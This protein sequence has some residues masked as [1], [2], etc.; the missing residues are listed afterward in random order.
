MLR[1]HLLLHSQPLPSLLNFGASP[2]AGALQAPALADAA[3]RRE[4]Q[5]GEPWRS[6]PRQRQVRIVTCTLSPCE[7][8]AQCSVWPRSLGDGSGSGGSLFLT[9]WLKR[10]VVLNQRSRLSH[11]DSARSLTCIHMQ[12]CSS[13]NCSQI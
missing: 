2:L 10:T 5:A 12:S 8:H 11:P 9:A 13:R 4:L 3:A 1:G 7:C 6:S